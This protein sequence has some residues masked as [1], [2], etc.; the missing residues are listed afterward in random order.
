MVILGINY[1]F[2]DTT[3]CVVVDGQMK[4]AIEE[5]RLTR[6]KHTGAFPENAV[7]KCLELCGLTPA[8][9]DHIAVSIDPRKYWGAKAWHALK[10]LPE[11]GPFI[12]HEILGTIYN[13]RELKA[14]YKKTFTST[15]PPVHYVEHHLAHVV[16]S[17][18]VSPYEEAALLSMDGAGE[19]ATS[20]LGYGRGTSY[21]T[22]AQSFF[23]NSLGSFYEAVTEFCGFKA[24][25]DE[26]KTMGL[27]PFGDPEPHYQK[28]KEIIAVDDRG[29]ITVD[30]KYF[31]FKMWAWQ[32]CSPLFYEV[33]G[34]P[35]DPK[36][37]FEKHH[38]D[39]AASF[40][41]VL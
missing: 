34:K 32:R 40:Q 27:A 23:P 3:A 13:Q 30:Q 20:L 33:F 36:A 22:F 6:N 11:V 38:M 10:N 35:R 19:W 26:G 29:R 18:Y 37:D 25:Y 8:D 5:E 16:G 41:R 24:N 12:R 7:K 15:R 28:V 4:A 9:V 17:F 1:F 21:E 31:N 39:V 14:W 2:H